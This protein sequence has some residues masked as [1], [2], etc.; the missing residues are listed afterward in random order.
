MF[1][2]FA[3]PHTGPRGIHPHLVSGRE[4]AVL[5]SKAHLILRSIQL[6]IGHDLLMQVPDCVI[7]L[8]STLKLLYSSRL[9]SPFLLST[10][11]L[12]HLLSLSSLS[13]LLLYLPLS[14]YFFSHSSAFPYPFPLSPSF[15]STCP[16][17]LSL[18][19]WQVFHKQLTL[20]SSASQSSDF[21]HWHNLIIST[22][23]VS[24]PFHQCML[25]CVYEVCKS[26]EQSKRQDVKKER[27]EWKEQ[28][29]V[30]LRHSHFQSTHYPS[31]NSL[32]KPHMYICLYIAYMYH[33]RNE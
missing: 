7:T 5:M 33:Y 25:F 20:A 17:T 31:Y 2:E 30:K 21:A 26:F 29:F 14:S 32:T 15:L 4:L 1:A 28:A 9:P 12:F 18:S 27:E 3:Q 8:S 6:K 11:S 19:L 10:L 22:A 13:S 24:Q 16:S 23:G